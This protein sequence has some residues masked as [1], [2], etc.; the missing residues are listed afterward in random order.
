MLLLVFANR[1][2]GGAVHQNVGR[3]QVRIDVQADRGVLAVLA[4]LLLELGHAV[5][6]THARDAIEHPGELGVLCDLALVEDD[7]L[8]RID[9]A[10]QECRGYLT[11]GARQ[12]GRVLPDGDGVQV[13]H[14]INAVIALLQRHEFGDRAEIIAEVQVAGRLHAGKDAFLERHR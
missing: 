10:G 7:L 11:R 3:H 4:G 13:D 1:H 5:E 14:A 12:F 2:V 8:F 6:P 9:A